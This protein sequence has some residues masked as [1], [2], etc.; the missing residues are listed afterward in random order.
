M[1]AVAALA[2]DLPRPEPLVADTEAGKIALR[3]FR[4]EGAGTDAPVY[5]NFH[6]GGFV[7][8]APEMDDHICRSLAARLGCVVL[9]PDYATAPG[10]RFP[11][12]P[13]QA[14]ALGWWAS[15]AGRK[16]GWDGKRIALGGQGAGANLAIGACLDLPARMGFKPLGVVATSPLLDLATPPQGLSRLAR[17]GL[18]AYLPDPVARAAPLASPMRAE[19]LAGFPPTLLA[20]GATDPWRG[21]AETFA[22]RLR[23]AG[24]NLQVQI[25]PGAGHRVLHAGPTDAA[26]EVLAAMS[27]FLAPLFAGVRGGS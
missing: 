4:P 27:D 20:F 18:A 17:A 23:Q 9:S 14:L 19:T 3:L 21:Q 6:G 24:A 22:D 26:A 5:I 13:T 8:P 7:L 25:A 2:G 11:A 15:F 12:A 16:L 10:A 1:A